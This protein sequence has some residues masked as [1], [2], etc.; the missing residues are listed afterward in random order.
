M[1]LRCSVVFCLFVAAQSALIKKRNIPVEIVYDKSNPSHYGNRNLDEKIQISQDDL[2]KFKLSEEIINERN[3]DNV[4][5]ISNEADGNPYGIRNLDAKI[6]LSPE[7]LGQA[8]K[9]L[10]DVSE[11]EENAKSGESGETENSVQEA[12]PGNLE[13][14][15]QKAEEIVFS[16]VNSIRNNIDKASETVSGT[17]PSPEAWAQL[18]QTLETFFRDQYKRVSLK[19]D[20]P[21]ENQNNNENNSQ[22]N[23]N[24]E[25]MQNLINGFQSIANNFLGNNFNQKPG[26]PEDEQQQQQQ[27]NPFQTLV[28]MFTGGKILFFK[29]FQMIHL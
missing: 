19:E 24:N 18:N 8:L 2:L 1:L 17:K 25:F 11:N 20:K 12:K 27:Q 29:Y 9:H 15:L 26:G 6:Q 23:Q 16:G 5:D 14:L 4:D 22:N 13:I 21:P 7:E 10:P 28:N 3:E